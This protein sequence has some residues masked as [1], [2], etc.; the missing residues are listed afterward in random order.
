MSKAKHTP[1]PWPY[2][3]GDNASIDII[4][5]NDTTITVDRQSRYTGKYVIERKEMEA[6]AR[7]IA[8]S[9]EMYELLKSFIS[10][11]PTDGTWNY[12]ACVDRAIHIIKKIEG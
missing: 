9:P 1:A 3:G 8:A 10:A 5:P 11:V 2:E 4:L 12:A 6:N 7:L